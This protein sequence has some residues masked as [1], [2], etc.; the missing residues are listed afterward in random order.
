[1]QRSIAAKIKILMTQQQLFTTTT[2]AAT[3]GE[4]ARVFT[5]KTTT[6]KG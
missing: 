5:T 3:A 6:I 2:L 1:L 4:A